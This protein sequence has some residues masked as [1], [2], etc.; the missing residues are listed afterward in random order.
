MR[1][2][3]KERL[4]IVIPTYDEADNIKNLISEIILQFQNI[5]F[6]III[7]DDGSTDNT[8][9]SIFLNFKND[10]NVK[11]IQREFDRGLLQSIKFAL[12]S[13]TG[14]KFVVMDGDGQHSPKDIRPLIEE[15]DNCDLVIGS[16]DLKNLTSMSRTR[17]FLSKLFNILVSFILSAKISDPL[18]GFFAGRVSLLNKKF[19]LLTNSGFKVLLDLIFSNRSN[20]INIAEKIIDFH[21]RKTGN[22][23]LGPQVMFSFMTQI[24]SYIFN[25]FL[26]SKLIG[27]FLIGS[28]GFL[29][30]IGILILCFNLVELSFFLS[31]TIATLV[32]A[33]INFILNNYLNFYNSRINTFGD[34][35]KSMF[36]YYLINLPGILSSIGGASFAYNV[37]SKNPFVSTL[38]GVFFDTMFKYFVS[39][40]WIWKSR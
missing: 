15:L 7:V 36:K 16:R 38:V 37:L 32:A 27:F 1:K 30:H 34:I 26:S 31:H 23:K 3:I 12:Q 6:E 40:S 28:F 29:I 24:I 35:I 14:E 9:E 8:V 13:I 2:F 18:T 5:D 11:V 4:S 25:G 17:I 22:S 39:K 10:Q 20:R 21:Y 33:S 19:F